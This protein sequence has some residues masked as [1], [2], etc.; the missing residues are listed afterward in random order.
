[1]NDYEARMLAE[2]TNLSLK[3]IAR[4]VSALIV[5]KG[6]SGSEIFTGG[7]K[8]EVPCVKAKRIEDPTG[9][10]D[11]FRAGVLYG[12]DN[13]MDW[14]NISR[15]ANL[16]GS[17]KISKKGT[18]NHKTSQSEIATLFYQEFGYKL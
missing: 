8:I 16:L 6:E 9:C 14:L 13:D 12:L 15:L 4:Q 7:K 1:V 18:Q 17:I 5:T 2:R 3:E 11:A 10:G